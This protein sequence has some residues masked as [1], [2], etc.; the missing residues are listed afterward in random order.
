MYAYI[1]STD[2]T[3]EL[4]AN[5]CL[6]RSCD[7]GGQI[8]SKYRWR[9]NQ[10]KSNKALGKYAADLKLFLCTRAAADPF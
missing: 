7:F 8:K 10:L 1:F 6:Q 9:K 2:Q 4:W 5:T 3:V